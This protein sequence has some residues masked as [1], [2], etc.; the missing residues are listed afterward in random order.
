M[1]DEPRG[2]DAHGVDADDGEDEDPGHALHGHED[3][4][5]E[6]EEGPHRLHEPHQPQDPQEPQHP[7]HHHRLA[8]VQAAA[9]LPGMIRVAHELLSGVGGRYNRGCPNPIVDSLARV[10]HVAPLPILKVRRRLLRQTM[11]LPRAV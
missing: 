2:E 6:V 3:A 7:H 8:Q 1:A 9:L 11:F 5:D 4:H 10:L